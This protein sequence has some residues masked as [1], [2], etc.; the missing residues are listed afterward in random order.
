MKKYII[1][2]IIALCFVMNVNAQ[3]DGFFNYSSSEKRTETWGQTP[4]LP[5]QHGGNNHEQAPLGSGLLILT[6]LGVVYKIR[7]EE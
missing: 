5:P 4:A 7:S 6:A 2:A 1:T 3:S